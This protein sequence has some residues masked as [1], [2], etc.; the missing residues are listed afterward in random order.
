M[1]PK[2]QKAVL[3]NVPEEKDF[4]EN[5]DQG[6]YAD[7]IDIFQINL[8]K[9]CNLSCKHCHVQA[10]PQNDRIMPKKYLQKCLDIL[11]IYPIDT[12]DITGGSPEMHPNLEWFLNELSQM[13]LNIMVRSNLVIL[14][15]EDYAHFIDVYTDNQVELVASLPGY[16][17][18]KV[19]RLRGEG[20]FDSSIEVLQ[21]LNQKGFGKE[22]TDFTLDL[23]Y[24]PAGSYLPGSQ[25]ALEREFK[26]QLNSKYGIVFDNLFSLINSP[27]GKFLNYLVKSDNYKNYMHELINSY[28]EETL[29]NVMCRNTVSVG[30]DGTLYDCD[31]NQMLNLPINNSHNHLSQFDYE[32]LQ[33]RRIE[34]GNHCYSCT[35]GGGSSCQGS[36]EE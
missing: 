8:C 22:D 27:V 10:S 20:V 9:K 21:L 34:I 6:L 17:Q 25:Q 31:F 14:L 2:K 29:Q 23:V 24:N 32:A 11:K 1:E 4:K 15:E 13:D 19:D 5:L 3:E 16:N 7:D 36:L 18:E 35:A 28:N 26:E 30:W 12:V 33:N